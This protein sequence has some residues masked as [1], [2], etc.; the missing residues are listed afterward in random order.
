MQRA[1]ECRD[2]IVA[3]NSGITCTQCFPPLE[4]HGAGERVVTAGG[5]KSR[6]K[7]NTQ[8]EVDP[9]ERGSTRYPWGEISHSFGERYPA[10]AIPLV[11]A[12]IDS[13]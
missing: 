9:N 1:A 5:A 12:S 3:G 4:S 7:P 11:T 10:Q 8:F 6:I 2:Y 13:A